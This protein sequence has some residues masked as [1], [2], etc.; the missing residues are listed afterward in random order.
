M[1]ILKLKKYGINPANIS[2][3]KQLNDICNAIEEDERKIFL[4][5]HY[6][7]VR[8][9]QDKQREEKR[10]QEDVQL[11]KESNELNK[12]TLKIAIWAFIISVISLLVSL[13]K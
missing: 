3:A 7:A 5:N 12:R 11:A 4:N 2:S 10:H 6:E 1:N 9:E 8:K 13:V